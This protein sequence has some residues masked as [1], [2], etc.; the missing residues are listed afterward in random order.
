MLSWSILRTLL[1]PLTAVTLAHAL[2]TVNKLLLQ[3]IQVTFSD[4]SFQYP[5]KWYRRLISAAPRRT[6]A[7]QNISFSLTNELILIT[8]NS[9]SGKTCM[10]KLIQ[11]QEKPTSGKLAISTLCD[12][13]RDALTQLPKPIYLELLPDRSDAHASTHDLLLARLEAL[14][15]GPAMASLI[16]GRFCEIV[17]YSTTCLQ[18]KRDQLSVSDN[19]KL[20]ILLACMESVLHGF[21]QRADS[22]DGVLRL[23]AP[24]LLLD[25]WLDK[26]TRTTVHRVQECLGKLVDA[27][28]VVLV[29]THKPDRWKLDH[30]RRLKLHLGRIQPSQQYGR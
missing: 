8:G 28:A 5:E 10:L 12:G 25:E 13:N 22:L 19:Y 16:L 21:D 26:E 11:E 6:Y 23:P 24:V 17:D 15:I 29:I 9:D 7:L 27:G 20:E 14:S 30:A 18:Q 3:P 4:V 1:I 2:S